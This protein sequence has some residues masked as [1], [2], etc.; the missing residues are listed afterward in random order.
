MRLGLER[1]RTAHAALTVITSLLQE[2]GQGGS[3]SVHVRMPY[4]NSFI[5]ADADEAHILETAGRHYAWKTVPEIGSIS[6][7]VAIGTDWS[8]L[9]D[10]ACE[11][12]VSNGWWTD[13]PPQRFDFSAAYR[14]TEMVPPQ[15]SEER[16][17]QS[18]KLLEEYRGKISPQT[19][20]RSLRDHYESG[21]VFTPGREPGDG[22]CYSICMHAD[23][24]GTT[25]ASMV[26]HLRGQG[27]LEVYW[28]SLGT[29]CCGVFMPLYVEGEIPLALTCAGSEYSEDSVWWL[30]KRLDEC[31][32]KDFAGKS[33]RVQAVWSQAETEF[34][35]KSITVEAEAKT[36]RADGKTEQARS[37]LTQFMEE[38]LDLV[39]TRLQE[40]LTEFGNE[41]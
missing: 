24:I 31:V 28:A 20:M 39:L 27:F 22:K 12:A 34:S 13:S 32:E 10:G 18:Q 19:M 15:I 21:T 36:L 5:I 35:K 8:A 38:N 3:G 11:Y 37:C 2:F 1:G 41:G 4:D 16:L 26:V 9:S 7:H 25:A 33:P 40:L 17:R 6:N 14:S 30:F 29:A 23:P